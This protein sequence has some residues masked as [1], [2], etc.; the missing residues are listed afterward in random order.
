MGIKTS[1]RTYGHDFAQTKTMCIV[2]AVVR[3]EEMQKCNSDAYLV[4]ECAV[5]C[6]GVLEKLYNGCMINFL[7]VITDDKYK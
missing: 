5:D 4:G 3:R 2:G 7:R 1:V 6:Q